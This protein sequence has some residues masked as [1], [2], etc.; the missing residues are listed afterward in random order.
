MSVH[1]VGLVYLICRL[2]N[3]SNLQLPDQVFE[4][5]NEEREEVF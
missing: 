4:T 3:P 5:D 2:T 1:Q